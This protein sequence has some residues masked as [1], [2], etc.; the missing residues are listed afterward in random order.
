[1]NSPHSQADLLELV[2]ANWVVVDWLPNRAVL[3]LEG[4]NS[5]P[6]QHQAVR[7]VERTQAPELAVVDK[8][9]VADHRPGQVRADSMPLVQRALL[10]WSGRNPKLLAAGELVR[11]E[12]SLRELPLMRVQQG[13]TRVVD[14][15]ERAPQCSR[16]RHSALP[17]E[18]HSNWEHRQRAVVD[19]SRNRQLRAV[20]AGGSGWNPNRQVAAR[21][22]LVP[23][24]SSNWLVQLEPNPAVLQN[25]TRELL[26]QA[27]Q[28]AE[29]QVDSMPS[30]RDWQ[31]EPV[32]GA[33]TAVA[34]EQTVE[35]PVAA[36][37]VEVV[38][39]VGQAFEADKFA[40]P[41][42]AVRIAAEEQTA[43]AVEARIE[44]EVDIAEQA[45]AEA[46]A[47]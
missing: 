16:L 5:S 7:I 28:M 30:A 45:E 22:V 40:E 31:Q 6:W 17:V 34:V 3:T 24:V 47:E 25:R 39:T 43:V 20:A 46:A 27:L 14:L 38:P 10:D 12:P 36:P 4:R 32:A 44:A 9:A 23:K 35:E 8:Q 26:R 21:R 37:L 13:S 18:R 1:M 29:L 42:V 41:T 33:R 2:P 11:V 19:W 15:L